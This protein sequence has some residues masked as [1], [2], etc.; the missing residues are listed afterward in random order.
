MISSIEGWP[1]KAKEA[2]PHD[3]RLAPLDTNPISS[4]L[5]KLGPVYKNDLKIASLIAHYKFMCRCCNAVVKLKDIFFERASE[6]LD[7]TPL[8]G[9]FVKTPK[10]SAIFDHMLLD[11]HKA[12]F[13]NFSMLLKESN[14]Y[15]LQLNESLLVSRDTPILNKNNYSFPFELFD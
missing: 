15:K 9:K 6:H 3:V 8:T 2:P 4:C 5:S 13:D 1:P 14:A 7:F 11:D 10:K 12:N